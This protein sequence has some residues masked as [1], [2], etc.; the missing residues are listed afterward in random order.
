MAEMSCFLILCYVRCS[1]RFADFQV[2]MML[3]IYVDSIALCI[4][5]VQMRVQHTCKCI[6]GLDSMD[7]DTLLYQLDL[8]SLTHLSYIEVLIH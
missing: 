6:C 4:S 7:K 5:E 1:K 8:L 2:L 3:C